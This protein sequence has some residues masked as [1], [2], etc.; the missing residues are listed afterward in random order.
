MM[1][2]I[3]CSLISL[4]I[5]GAASGETVLLNFEQAVQLAYDHDHRIGEKEKLIGVAKGLLEEANGAESWIYDV[6]AFLGLS[7]RIKR[8]NFLDDQG[9][10][11]ASAFDFDGVSPW[12]NLEFKI[13]YPLATFGKVENYAKA[14]KNNIRLKEGDVQIQRSQTYV[15]VATAYNGFLAARDTRLLLEDAKK[16]LVSATELVEGWLADGEGTAKQSDL[17]ALQT[18]GAMVERYLA[19]AQGLEN[20]A[21]AGLKLLT[22]TGDDKEIELA[23]KRLEPLP[24]PEES[25]VILRDMALKNR[26][27]MM[28][29]EAGLTARRALVE[30]N[31]AEYHPN[32]YAGV[33]GVISYS[34][35][36]EDTSDVTVYDPFNTAG[37]TPVIGLKWDWYS[38]RQEAHVSQAQAELDALL[39]KQSFALQGIP[40]QVTEAYYYVQSHHKMVQQLYEGSRAGRRWLISTY[41]DFEAGVEGSDKVV[42][43]FQGYLLVYSD[44]LKVVNNYNLHIAK[45]KVAIG[46]VK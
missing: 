30:A 29:V 46:E 32:L 8:G 26:P 15:D 23:D 24:L 5:S 13:V 35:L 42:S 38:G 33:G 22:G 44:Y 20:I 14:A 16:K 17:Y 1:R 19:E 12:Y 25:V 10:F 43:A 45:L 7:P 18:G 36:R 39:E 41:A 34:P 31:K 11:D 3:I 21:Y 28:Q 37:A 9:K 4:F 6:N 2:F 27:E 40:F